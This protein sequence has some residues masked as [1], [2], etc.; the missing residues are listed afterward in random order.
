LERCG[1]IVVDDLKG[2]G[3]GV[4]D[5]HLLGAEPVLEQLVLD[6]LVGK[7]AG[8]IEAERLQ[9]AGQ[10]FHGGDAAGLDRLDELGSGSEGEVGAA[11]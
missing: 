10:H 5:A 11:P 3:I 7:R 9:I 4:V 1:Q 8:G 2:A 6:A